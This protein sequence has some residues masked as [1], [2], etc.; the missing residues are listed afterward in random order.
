MSTWREGSELSRFNRDER[1]VPFP[2]SPETLD[3]FEIAQDVSRRSRGAFDVTVGPLVRAWG[4]GA[5][6]S[7]Q[8]QTPPTLL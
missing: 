2:L 5:G 6:A 7:P 8:T 4:F 3:V 1:T